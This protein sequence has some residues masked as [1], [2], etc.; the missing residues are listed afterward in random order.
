MSAKKPP[1]DKISN[2]AP[3]GLRMPA[4]LREGIDAAATASGR[5]MNAEIVERLTSSL[6]AVDPMAIHIQMEAAE[7]KIKSLRYDLRAAID[8]SARWRELYL[9]K[10]R[11][12]ASWMGLIQVLCEQV[13]SHGAAVPP[14]LAKFA[15]NVLSAVTTTLPTTMQVLEDAKAE[16]QKLASEEGQ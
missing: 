2:I 10:Q 11:S 8:Q 13:L 4:S 6:T 14:E 1:E 15:N 5:S 9:E 16:E 12:D 7:Q 3:F